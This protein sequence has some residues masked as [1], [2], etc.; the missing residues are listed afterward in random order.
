MDSEKKM[1]RKR[2]FRGENL[3]PGK[4]LL[5]DF[6]DAKYP[7]KKVKRNKQEQQKTKKR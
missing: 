5:N 7:G 1:F 4:V 6:K 2:Q 3:P